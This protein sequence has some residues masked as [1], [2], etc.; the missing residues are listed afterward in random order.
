MTN[1]MYRSDPT[2]LPLIEAMAAA[3]AAAMS[4]S[5]EP[6]APVNP[7]TP[8]TS[9]LLFT[10][11][12]TSAHTNIADHEYRL[13]LRHRLHL[14]V[15]DHLPSHCRSCKEPMT[16]DPAHWHSCSS[17]RKKGNYCRHEKI[18]LCLQTLARRAGIFVTKERRFA[19]PKGRRP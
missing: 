9:E 2:P 16:H 7:T 4:D 11:Y 19:T 8:S 18:V 6:D 13:A 15:V 12:P 17:R 14:P 3:T 10:T 5:G 1:K